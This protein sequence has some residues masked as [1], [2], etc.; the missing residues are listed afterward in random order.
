MEQT[1]PEYEVRSL[2]KSK[3]GLHAKKKVF[4]GPGQVSSAQIMGCQGIQI[5]SGEV[6]IQ[7]FSFH[8]SLNGRNDVRMLPKFYSWFTALIMAWIPINWGILFI[9]V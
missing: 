5:I 7:G 4:L 6:V 8:Q 2:G 9:L 1:Q 3:K